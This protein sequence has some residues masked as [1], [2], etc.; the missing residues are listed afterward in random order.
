V[1]E[2]IVLCNAKTRPSRDYVPCVVSPLRESLLV[3]I[4]LL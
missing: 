3:T 1:E 2:K 4:L